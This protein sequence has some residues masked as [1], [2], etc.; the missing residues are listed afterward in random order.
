MPN[1]LPNSNLTE[2]GERVLLTLWK[3]NGVGNR[4]VNEEAIKAEIA[5]A[6]IQQDLGAEIAGLRAM[7][8]LESATTDGS[9]MLS[10]TSLGLSVLRQLEE[11]KLQELK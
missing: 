6:G 4:R 10:L 5:A 8:F 1:M 3:L 11:D 7:G 9:N 2:L